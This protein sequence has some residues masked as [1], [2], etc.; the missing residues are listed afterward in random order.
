[1]EHTQRNERVVENLN[2][3]LHQLFEAEPT[4]YLVGE[5]LLDPY[6]GA[7]KVSK[8]LST[9]F[10]DRVLPT[11]IAE[12]AIVGIAGGLALQG[13]KPIAEIMFGDFIALAFDQILN[14]A[15][16]SVTMYGERVPLHLLVRC[17]VGGG[18]GYG[19]THSQS[20]QK[21][22]VGIPNLELYEVS[23]LHDNVP[24][25][26]RL[27]NLGHPAI[28]FE[29]KM[30]YAQRMPVGAGQDRG[31]IDEL[32]HFERLGGD[33]DL[34]RVFVPDMGTA[35]AVLIAAGGVFHRSLTAARDLLVEH[36]MNV[37]M[38]VPSRIYP[39]D[40]APAERLLADARRILT[41]EESTAGGTWG[42]EV[43]QDIYRRLWGR[44]QGPVRVVSTRDSIIPSSA[45]L[46]RRVLVQA[47]DIYSAVIAA[48]AEEPAYV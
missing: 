34:V 18:R 21:H 43:A 6:G 35:D 5:D 31:E 39:L 12:N 10:P 27:V 22:F 24:L 30:L 38:L 16:K 2:R 29:D 25:L 17:P 1:M 40:L 13:E 9:H 23:P 14:F 42:A 28:L 8:G 32:F 41:V 7:F 11:P 44:L 45:H 4:T 47:A 15:S 46:E 3:A 37:E 36:E 20:V 33:S 48:C 26:P 19:P